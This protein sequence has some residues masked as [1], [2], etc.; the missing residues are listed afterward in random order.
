MEDTVIVDHCYGKYVRQRLEE[1]SGHVPTAV[2][3]ASCTQNSESALVRDR[4]QRRMASY[5][6]WGL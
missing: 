1:D 2:P 4:R 6:R 3:G 5:L